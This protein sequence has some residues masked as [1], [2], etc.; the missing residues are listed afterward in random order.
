MCSERSW[1]S[2]LVWCVRDHACFGR[3]SY[4]S[5]SIDNEEVDDGLP[6]LDGHDGNALWTLSQQDRKWDCSQALK[7][8]S[9]CEALEFLNLAFSVESRVTTTKSNNKHVQSL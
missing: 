8:G 6:S 7:V 3:D 9:N 4:P 5:E 1:S 2:G